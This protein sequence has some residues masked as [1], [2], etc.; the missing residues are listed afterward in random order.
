[1]T[2][3]SDVPRSWTD[4]DERAR[5]DLALVSKA[6]GACQTVVSIL[7]LNSSELTFR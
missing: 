4:G 7:D 6:C 5:E 3:G 2:Q 1:M